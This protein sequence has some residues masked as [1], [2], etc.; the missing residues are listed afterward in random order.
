MIH[1]HVHTYYSFYEGASSPEE[2]FEAARERGIDTLAVTD[3]NG[4]YG[5]IHQRKAAE[6]YRL[7]LL[8]GAWLDDTAGHSAVI[9]PRTRRGY[10]RLCHLVT[11]RHMDPQFSLPKSLREEDLSQLFV[12]SPDIELLMGLPREKTVFFELRPGA[13]H[14]YKVVRDLGIPVVATNGVYFAHP[15]EYEKHQLLRVVGLNSTFSRLSPDLHARKDQWLKPP[16]DMEREF[17]WAP[18]ALVNSSVIAEN[19]EDY[20]DMGAWVVP[21]DTTDETGDLFLLLNTI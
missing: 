15:Q 10:S 1:L 3:T 7:R 16:E 20:W 6:Q 18:E 17:A 2:L 19:I 12:F 21:R 4:L 8:I 14:R 9:L 13:I 11:W 5:L